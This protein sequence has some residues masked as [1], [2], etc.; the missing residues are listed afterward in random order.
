MI[1]A[2]LHHHRYLH[3]TTQLT[4]KNLSILFKGTPNVQSQFAFRVIFLSM[5]ASRTSRNLQCGLWDLEVYNLSNFHPTICHLRHAG[6]GMSDS[7]TQNISAS[8]I[9]RDAGLQNY[10]NFLLRGPATKITKQ[11]WDS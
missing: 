5:C 9:L 10:R 7:C 8:H 3:Q 6:C 2:V 4:M 11:K 1:H